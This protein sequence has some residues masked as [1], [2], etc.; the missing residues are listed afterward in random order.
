MFRARSPSPPLIWRL[1]CKQNQSLW[2]QTI[3]HPGH[4]MRWWNTE[5]VCTILSHSGPCIT[6]ALFLYHCSSLPLPG[7]VSVG[8]EGIHCCSCPCWRSLSRWVAVQPLFA[9]LFRSF[10]EPQ[11]GLWGLRAETEMKA[12]QISSSQCLLIVLKSRQLTIIIIVPQKQWELN[13]KALLIL[14]A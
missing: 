8:P 5:A 11:G 1:W 7:C 9:G 13:W 14:D 4:T 10:A 2:A 6:Q 12:W 3:V